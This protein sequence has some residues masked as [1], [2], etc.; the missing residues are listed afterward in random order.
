MFNL[1][2]KFKEQNILVIGD[3]ILDQYIYG[4]V[5]RINPEAPVPI[6]N[7]SK[8]EY[9]LGG[10]ANVAANIVSLGGKCTLIGQV[11]N[12]AA[13]KKIISLLRKKGI[14]FKLVER[15]D[16]PTIQKTRIIARSQ[17]VVRVDREKPTEITPLFIKEIIHF[18]KEEH[19]QRPF[20]LIILSDYAKGMLVRD[21]VTELKK[22]KIKIIADPKP[23]NMFQFKGVFLVTPNW[24][25]AQEIAQKSE[26]WGAGKEIC[27]KY[28]CHTVITRGGE[29]CFLFQ[30][31]FLH[32]IKHQHFPIPQEVG[33][34][35]VVGAGD[36]FISALSLSLAAGADFAQ[37]CTLAN[38][39]AGISVS[40]VGTAT[41]SPEELRNVWE[42]SS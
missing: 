29:G 10:A 17:Q 4:D 38:L 30:R 36:T 8:V 20:S 37:A 32:G 42:R 2:E 40:K 26:L 41:V 24:K 16:F 27:Q 6:L 12:D 1:I 25:E 21:L 19:R 33:V 22:L 9:V 15:D 14:N 23:Q 3:I 18:V 5:T 7:M 28:G 39:A 11:G 13:R 31:K 35:D 34:Y